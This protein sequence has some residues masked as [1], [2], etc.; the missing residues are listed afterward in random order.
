MIKKIYKYTAALLLAASLSLC[1]CSVDISG[2]LP[3]QAIVFTDTR[4][5]ESIPESS[6]T[7]QPQTSEP[8]NEEA[9]PETSRMIYESSFPEEY[10]ELVSRCVFVGDSICSGLSAYGIVPEKNVVAQGNVAARNIFDYTFDVG[11]TEVS[12]L[13]ALV[14]LKPEYIVFSMGMNDVNITSQDTFCENYAEIVS[15]TESFIP[16]AKIIILSVT[17]VLAD[18]KFTSNENIDSFNEA[19]KNYFADRQDVL[20]ADISTAIKNESNAL[21]SDYSGGDGVH[22]APGAYYDIL[23]ELC[24]IVLGEI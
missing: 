18:S 1:G 17:P 5:K 23:Y 22:L 3:P 20:F 4:E 10:S 16:D 6:D 9:P 7:G 8:E 14:D 11:G 13:P 2:G 21:R 19:L 15:L 12:L 24:R